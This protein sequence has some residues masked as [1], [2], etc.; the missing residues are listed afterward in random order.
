MNIEGLSKLATITEFYLIKAVDAHTYCKFKVR[1]TEDEPFLKKKLGDTVNI[2]LQER[3]LLYGTIETFSV[4]ETFSETWMEV[5]LYSTSIYEDREKKVRVFQNTN[6]TYKDVLESLNSTSLEIKVKG[7]E[8]DGVI[9]S[10]VFQVE[11]TNFEFI[12]RI[13]KE[14]N[15]YVF[16][17]DLSYGAPYLEISRQRAGQ[18]KQIPLKHV[19]QYT[20]K[21][22]INGEEVSIA[23]E[24]FLELGQPV[25]LE[26][27]SYV[28]TQVE[29]EMQRDVY[30]K[31]YKLSE[32]DYTVMQ[33]IE[34]IAY[35][36][37]AKVVANKD[38]EGLGRLQLDFQLGKVEEK[39]STNRVWI[40]YMTPYA[41]ATGGIVFLP[42]VGDIVRVQVMGEYVVA[43]GMVRKE[44]VPKE[45]SKA[46]NKYIVSP[47]GRSIA[48]TEE[49]I[50]L[51]TKGSEMCLSDE[52][53]TLKVGNNK[54]LLNEKICLVEA[55]GIE[56]VAKGK[57]KIK[58]DSDVS[59]SAGTVKIKGSSGVELG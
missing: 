25:S 50:I 33:K 16:V 30:K 6:K 47:L 17:E 4:T 19:K 28:V 46:Q 21:R 49:G 43:T 18:E 56:L 55:E 31:H 44:A 39:E 27:K 59:V 24:E 10:L 58:A 34:S 14:I 22:G 35:E 26:G 9:S 57:M 51:Q 15:A 2:K 54:V 52:G 45:F 23:L 48:L 32:K 41:A 1:T 29:I 37:E 36:F 12:K 20:C 3:D 5:E 13:A 7:K 53:I 42:E 38:S 8:G 40:P 11:E